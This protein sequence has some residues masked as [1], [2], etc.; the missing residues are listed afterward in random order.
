MLIGGASFYPGLVD[1]DLIK[2]MAEAGCREVSLGFEKLQDP[3]YSI[4]R[5]VTLT[6]DRN[7]HVCY[8]QRRY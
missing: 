7:I 3:A 4:T 8:A 5:G 2:L 1:E 6:F